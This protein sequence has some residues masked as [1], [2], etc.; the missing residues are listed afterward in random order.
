MRAT[1]TFDFKKINAPFF[2][3]AS[4]QAQQVL[5]SQVEQWAFSHRLPHLHSLE[6]KHEA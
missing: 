6:L 5:P 1:A 4:E 3:A 2:S